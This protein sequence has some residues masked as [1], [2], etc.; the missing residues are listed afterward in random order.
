MKEFPYKQS[1]SFVIKPVVSEE[2]DKYLALA[3][4]EQLRNFLPEGV[5]ETK[6]FLPIAF[7]SFTPNRANKN[8]DVL[9]TETSL[10]IYKKFINHPINIEHKRHNIVGVILTAGLSEFGTDKPLTE[11]EV[12]G[13]NTP[14]NVTLGGIL[15][16][17]VNNEL[18]EFVEDSNDPSSENYLGVSASWELGFTD[19][20]LVTLPN[21]QKNIENGEIFASEEDINKYKDHLRALG[22]D[23]LLD[24]KRLYRMP[25]GEVSPLGIGLTEKPAADVKG[26]A[27]TLEKEE[28][29]ELENKA[30]ENTEILNN[31]SNFENNISQASKTIVN[32]ERKPA[33]KI[34]SIAD[35]TDENLKEATASVIAEVISTHLT[36]KSKEWE[37]EKTK[38]ESEASKAAEDYTKLKEE[39]EKVTKSLESVQATINALNA[40]KE[41]REKVE[42]FNVRMSEIS[43]AY[44]LDDEV[45]AALVEEIKSLASDEDFTKWK[46]R[47]SV[48][49]KGFAKTK[50]IVKETEKESTASVVD[51]ALD[52]ANKEK[53]GLPNSAETKQQT[54]KEKYQ[55]AF[56]KEGFDIK[57]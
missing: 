50:E 48:L 39:Y 21:G 32:T 22:G 4:L 31:N 57:L 20:K 1:F 29:S 44:N 41:E 10:A 3:S 9:D 49:L 43:E 2:K 55:S 24:G 51:E 8:D 37:S 27:T 45:R 19:Y 30:K 25:C 18:A 46:K 28:D 26:V 12:K 53:G 13:K 6:Q 7:N 56:A 11:E 16:R 17:V 33:M 15:W 23:G 47:A 34:N 35:I 36:S 40:E 54:L 52:K 5:K 42:K 14:F 38:L